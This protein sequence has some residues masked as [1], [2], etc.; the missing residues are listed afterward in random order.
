[1]A[2]SVTRARW[3]HVGAFFAGVSVTLLVGAGDPYAGLDVFARVVS[4]VEAHHQSEPGLLSIVHAALRGIPAVLDE[5]SAYYSP[6]EWTRLRAV[7]AGLSVGIGVSGSAEACGLRVQAVEAWSPAAGA[8]VEVGDCLVGVDAA[9]LVGPASTTVRFT[10]QRADTKL[11]KVV[12]RG[13]PNPPAVQVER[14]DG[15][16]WYARVRH[17]GDDVDGRLAA[18]LPTRPVPKGLLLDLR[19]NPGGE[20]REAAELV[21]RFV[22]TGVIVTTTVRGEPEGVVN[23]TA[24][25]TDWKFPVVLIVDGQTASAAEIVA[26]ALQDHKRALLVGTRTWGKAAVLRFFQYEDGSALKLT[27]GN[28]RLPT[29]RTVPA[30]EGLSPDRVVAAAAVPVPA[31]APL[32]TRLLD[33]PQLAAADAALQSAISQPER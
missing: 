5:H 19:G 9:S 6:E 12:L 7:E 4:D 27:V 30:R 28:Y 29:G 25:R 11:E 8:G 15:G 31:D 18:A 10:L 33:D 21:D 22:G 32:A 16:R 20:V 1:M 13:L 17:F 2:R 24:A 14:L 26:G 23:A 3:G